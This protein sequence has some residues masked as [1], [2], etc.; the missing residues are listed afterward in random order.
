M[1]RAAAN[2]QDGIREPRLLAWLLLATVPA[3][4]MAL[5]G[6]NVGEGLEAGRASQSANAP[7]PAAQKQ[8]PEASQGPANPSL[9]E[10]VSRLISVCADF[11]ADAAKARNDVQRNNIE[12]KYQEA[13]EAVVRAA[14]FLK[15]RGRVREIRPASFGDLF[16]FEVEAGNFAF[17]TAYWD[18]GWL[19]P[20]SKMGAAASAFGVGDCIV[21]SAVP[22]KPP[23]TLFSVIGPPKLGRCWAGVAVEFRELQA[24][25]TSS[26]GEGAS[27]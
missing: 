1:S 19:S 24:C 22:A 3:L 27:R 18:S 8:A 4:Q 25:A 9:E 16:Y 23:T 10:F 15:V 7:P 26:A 6:C 5:S 2:G 12:S 14:V 20:K 13:A 11:N 17:H 21:F